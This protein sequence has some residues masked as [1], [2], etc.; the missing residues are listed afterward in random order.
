M[1][2]TVSTNKLAAAFKT[3]SGKT[4][5]VLFEE[6]YESNCYPRTPSWG[7]WSAA[8]PIAVAPSSQGATS[9]TTPRG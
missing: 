7:A 6:T 4:M 5:Y 8:Q 1:G 2:S 9:A 3:N